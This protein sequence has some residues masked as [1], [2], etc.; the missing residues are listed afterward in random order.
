MDQPQ[1]VGLVERLGDLHRVR[2]AAPV[3]GRELLLEAFQLARVAGHFRPEDLDGHYTSRRQVPALV[4]LG[5]AAL[6]NPVQDLVVAEPLHRPLG[7]LETNHP[8]F[9]PWSA[10]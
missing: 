3:G 4:D 6:A 9:L 8:Q 5:H 10:N 2:M 1:P 7:T